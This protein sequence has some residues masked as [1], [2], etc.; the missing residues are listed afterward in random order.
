MSTGKAKWE[1]QPRRE[2]SAGRAAP[3]RVGVSGG[4]HP[5]SPLAGRS[6]CCS[7]WSWFCSLGLCRE[8]GHGKDPRQKRGERGGKGIFLLLCFPDGAVC[9]PRRVLTQPR[10]VNRGGEVEATYTSFLVSAEIQCN[11][12]L[13]PKELA[14]TQGQKLCKQTVPSAASCEM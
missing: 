6:C 3:Q 13:R 11:S 2:R 1:C 14:F 4:G 7:H 12:T 5:V 10:V 9:S 8:L